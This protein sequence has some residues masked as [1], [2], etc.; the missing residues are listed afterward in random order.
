MKRSQQMAMPYLI[1]CR[2]Y[3]KAAAQ[4]GVSVTQIYE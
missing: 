2:S 1:S 4:M 3:K